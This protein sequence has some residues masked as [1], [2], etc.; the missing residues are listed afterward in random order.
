MEAVNDR[1]LP[2]LFVEIHSRKAELCQSLDDFFKSFFKL[3]EDDASS[4][5]S[6]LSIQ[7]VDMKASSD[8]NFTCK[9]QTYLSKYL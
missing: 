3:N 2:L 8:V 7:C 1:I 5:M 6:V 9:M 4:S